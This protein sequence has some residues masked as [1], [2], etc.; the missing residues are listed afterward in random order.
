M[1]DRLKFNSGSECNFSG[2]PAEGEFT[3]HGDPAVKIEKVYTI[4][5]FP[6]GHF[7]LSRC[8]DGSYWAHIGV[9]QPGN[10]MTKAGRVVDARIDPG[11]RRYASEALQAE[12]VAVD[13][14]HFALRIE[15]AS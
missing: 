11:G 6:G 10:V 8:E 9:E 5:H 1:G 13:A 12:F 4:I 15:V 3:L 14:R 7:E 2:K